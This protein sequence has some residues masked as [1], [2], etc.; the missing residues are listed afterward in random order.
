MI[1]WAVKLRIL[2]NWTFPF[3][4]KFDLVVFKSILGGISSNGNDKLKKEVIDEIYKCLKPNG[5][6]LFAE[7]LE[8]SFLHKTFRKIF[9]KWG[10]RWNYLKHEEIENI[11]DSFENVK[12]TS[13]GFFGTFGRTERQRHFLSKV[14][15]FIVHFIPKKKRYI[16]FGIADHCGF[17]GCPR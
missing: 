6:L 13:V 3:E 7:N 17:S 16:V 5:K 11:F 9:V 12:Y 10:N 4:N 8:S 2:L 14:D 15:N 1:I